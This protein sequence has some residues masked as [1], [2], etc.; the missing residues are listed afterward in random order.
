MHGGNDSQNDGNGRHALFGGEFHVVQGVFTQ[1][2]KNL[3]KLGIL[4]QNAKK[5]TKTDTEIVL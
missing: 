3:K 5:S 2:S 1:F 4:G